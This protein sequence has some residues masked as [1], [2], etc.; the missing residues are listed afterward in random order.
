MHQSAIKPRMRI[1]INLDLT[2]QVLG[3]VWEMQGVPA[4]P[5]P[6]TA[7]ISGDDWTEI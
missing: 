1:L 3:S 5:S 7:G 4:A 2:V 6:L